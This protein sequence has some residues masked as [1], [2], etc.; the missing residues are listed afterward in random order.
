MAS[1]NQNYSSESRRSQSGPGSSYYRGENEGGRYSRGDDDRDRDE[2][3]SRYGYSAE[4]DYRQS[5]IRGSGYGMSSYGQSG[6]GQGG[7]GQ[8]SYGDDYRR[9]SNYGGGWSEPYGEG[10]QYGDRNFEQS[11]DF[12]R[13]GMHRGKGPKGYQRSDERIKE[14]VCERLRDDPYIDA[15]DITVTVQGGRVA[16]EGTVDSRATK[17]AVED[18]A[19]QCTEQDVQNNLR[20]SRG[21]Q[22]QGSAGRS[23]S[24]RASL[25]TDESD[26]G[27]KQKRN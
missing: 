10:Q 8:P 25:G 11:G 1:R 26:N 6:Y 18:I 17:N 12:R 21:E 19:E 20:V 3:D 7:Y 2:R 13:Q 5:V 27:V 22:G 9:S 14:V 24:N 16:L 23:T 15:S 4:G